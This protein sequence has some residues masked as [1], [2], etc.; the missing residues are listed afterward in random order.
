MEVLL[1][2]PGWIQIQ[3]LDGGGDDGLFRSTRIESRAHPRCFFSLTPPSG[4][5][6]LTRIFGVSEKTEHDRA[7]A[8]L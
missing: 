3:K 8:Y 7:L 4:I 5:F 1:L 2:M 6:F